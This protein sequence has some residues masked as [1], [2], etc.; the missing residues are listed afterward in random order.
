MALTVF[1]FF[2]P[3]KLSGVLTHPANNWCS[4][5]HHPNH[6]FG[7]LK[8]TQHQKKNRMQDTF[9]RRILED[10]ASF[11]GPSATFHQGETIGQDIETNQGLN[12]FKTN[13]NIT[14]F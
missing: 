5:A 11:R 2:S 4:G 1:I 6:Q 8:S 3:L 7:P 13:T 10:F 9:G 12:P 14:R